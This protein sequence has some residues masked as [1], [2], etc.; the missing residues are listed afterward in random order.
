MGTSNKVL[1]GAV[2]YINLS[3]GVAS[4]VMNDGFDWAFERMLPHLRRAELL[5]G[6]LES[7]VSPP[8]YPAREIDPKGLIG[9]RDPAPALKKAGFDFLNLAQNHILDA[10]V[11]G[12]FHTR[13]IIERAGIA[14]GGIGNTQPEARRLRILEKNGLRF[15]FLCYCEDTNYSLSTTGPCHAYYTRET[16]LEDVARHRDA[17]D[18]LVISIHADLEFMPTPSVPRQQIM[19][20]IARAGATLIL[21]H[22]PHV[23]QGIER[24]GDSLVVY[25]LGN[26][27]FASHSDSYMRENLPHT[28][29]SFLLLAEVE[30]RRVNSFTRVPLIISPAP[31]ERPAPADGADR[32]RLLAYFAELDALAADEQAVARVWRQLAID[33]L[34]GQLERLK[35]MT[36]DDLLAE[37]LGRLLLV[38]ENRSWVNEVMRVVQENWAKQ[39]NT[40][41]P[42]HRPHY[43]ITNRPK[44][45]TPAGT[46]TAK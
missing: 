34:A 18:V 27:V 11:P 24:I 23:P 25:S 16:V 22:H 39:A 19:R 31:E 40:I 29:H 10:G 42:L 1:F 7:V 15:G 44:S 43:V 38:Q 17:V 32:D 12:M 20:E 21:A 2:G 26:F 14:T 3:G 13:D 6:N 46:N 45:P 9:Q 5:F 4:P 41:D 8:D 33:R 35:T 28:G 36:C 30:R 37:T